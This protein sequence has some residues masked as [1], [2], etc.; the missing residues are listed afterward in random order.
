MIKEFVKYC[1]STFT[2]IKVFKDFVL[3]IPKNLIELKK[4]DFKK[5]IF[6]TKNPLT[7]IFK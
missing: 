5:E 6:K 1:K 2:D 4:S 7:D 3:C